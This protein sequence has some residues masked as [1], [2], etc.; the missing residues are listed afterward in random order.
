MQ[1]GGVWLCAATCACVKPQP[2]E[3]T[4]VEPT[5]TDDAAPT[6]ETATTQRDD[7]API[8]EPGEPEHSP[9]ESP[10]VEEPPLDAAAAKAL[11][12]EAWAQYRAGEFEVAGKSFE[13]LARHDL[14]AWEHPYNVARAASRGGDIERATRWFA[15]AQRR[16]RDAVLG[17][18]TS[19][20]DLEN[21]RRDPVWKHLTDGDNRRRARWAAELMPEPIALDVHTLDVRRTDSSKGYLLSLKLDID[22][23]KIAAVE[24]DLEVF[25]VCKTPS[26]WAWDFGLAKPKLDDMTV[27]SRRQTSVSL[28]ANYHCPVKLDYERCQ[29]DVHL[30]KPDYSELQESFCLTPGNVAATPGACDDFEPPSRAAAFEVPH[31]VLERESKRE[32]TVWSC[33]DLTFGPTMIETPE[34]IVL[35]T[36]CKVGGRR[37]SEDQL[38]LTGSWMPDVGTTVNSTPFVDLEGEPSQCQFELRYL[39]TD[40]PVPDTSKLCMANRD[41]TWTPCAAAK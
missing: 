16:D 38:L 41:G 39:L 14:V 18:R 28:F 31:I 40:K 29:F 17:E 12:A 8:A 3:P 22:V 1:R 32:W 30:R 10:V 36:T 20:P 2:V 6:G 13:R 7:A 23:S 19:D 15:L 37:V 24:G 9:S 4:S 25:V 26:D 33:V 21:L 11:E 27:G 35:R 5:P 34:T